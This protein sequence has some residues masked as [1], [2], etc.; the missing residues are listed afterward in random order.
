M[1]KAAVIIV[2]VFI[3]FLMFYFLINFILE[4]SCQSNDNK[5]E[6]I[7][8][9]YS[10]NWNNPNLLT[11]INKDHTKTPCKECTYSMSCD[12]LDDAQPFCYKSFD[13]PSLHKNKDKKYYLRHMS[14]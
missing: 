1:S 13:L 6:F 14:Y 3:L 7:N 4:L 8:D 9:Y 10:W 5:E 12:L 2:T 11:I